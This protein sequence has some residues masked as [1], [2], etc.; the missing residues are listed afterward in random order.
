MPSAA[1]L[2]PI[3]S[4]P[5]AHGHLPT[6]ARLLS[7]PAP[8]WTEAAAAAA[9]LDAVRRGVVG[10]WV[11]A[12]DAGGAAVPFL[13][14]ALTP[15]GE[16]SPA[17]APSACGGSSA[18]KRHRTSPLHASGFARCESGTSSPLSGVVPPG[19]PGTFLLS[20]RRS[21]SS[22][23]AAPSS[24]SGHSALVRS[25]HSLA[26]DPSQAPAAS[27]C[28]SSGLPSPGGASTSSESMD[29]RHPERKRPRAGSRELNIPVPWCPGEA[30]SHHALAF[31]A[32][33]S[34]W[35]QPD[36]DRPARGP[37]PSHSPSA[38]SQLRT[39]TSGMACDA[40]AA[41]SF[42]RWV[43]RPDLRISVP[44]NATSSLTRAAG[45]AGGAFPGRVGAFAPDLAEGDG[46]DE[47]NLVAH[48]PWLDGV[49]V[50]GLEHDS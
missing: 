20:G 44:I 18:S 27:H 26:V 42:T 37:S 40:P 13:A 25:F 9:A 24:L 11:F 32:T 19:P 36:A 3:D 4:P 45:G 50:H 47:A 41:P 38:E 14:A 10:P 43:S 28:A 6:L 34:W 29:Y 16:R 12:A 35:P 21:P 23:W 8:R 1:S 46:D 30:E 5:T 2:H 48:D 15:P 22:H 17:R 31:G 33:R 49:Q 7:A 39:G